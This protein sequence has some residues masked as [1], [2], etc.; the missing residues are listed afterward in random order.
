[1]CILQHYSVPS[2]SSLVLALFL[3]FKAHSVKTNSA[4]CLQPRERER[5]TAGVPGAENK[6]TTQLLFGGARHRLLCYSFVR[7][8]SQQRLRRKAALLSA[9]K[10]ILISPRQSERNAAK[11]ASE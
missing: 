9:T 5:E 10:L 7:R 1:M 4:S 2:L 6:Y 3:Y 8:Y 11:A